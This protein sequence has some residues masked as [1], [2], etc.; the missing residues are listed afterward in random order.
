MIELNAAG[1]FK[2]TGHGWVAFID[3]SDE[4]LPHGVDPSNLLSQC[5]RIDGKEYYVTGVERQG[6]S[7]KNF[8]L[9]VRGEK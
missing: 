2:I 5:V 1:W 8:G 7:R 9:L 4:Q 3:N 6:Y